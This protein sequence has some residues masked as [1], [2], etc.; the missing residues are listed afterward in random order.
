MSEELWLRADG[1]MVRLGREVKA[2]FCLLP[3]YSP[4]KDY[5]ELLKC[6]ECKAC[7]MLSDTPGHNEWHRGLIMLIQEASLT[8]DPRL[9][10]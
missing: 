7:V 3:L 6:P 1:K 5:D 8:S 4:V 2:P 10:P 9:L